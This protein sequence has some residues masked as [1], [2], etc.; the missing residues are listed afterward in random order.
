MKVPQV[1]VKI[2]HNHT[3]HSLT[4]FEPLDF[5]KSLELAGAPPPPPF[6]ADGGGGCRGRGRPP[7]AFVGGCGG[8]GQ[9]LLNM[10]LLYM[11]EG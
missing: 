5:R 4:G 2:Q 8:G 1:V 10:P 3:Y 9:L 11:P 7:T 6:D